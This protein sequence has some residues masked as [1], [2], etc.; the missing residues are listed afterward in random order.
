MLSTKRGKDETKAR[1]LWISNLFTCCKSRRC[2]A[3]VV[4]ISTRFLRHGDA[5]VAFQC[6]FSFIRH[7]LDCHNYSEPCLP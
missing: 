4:S 5:L 1:M 2:S 3:T 6:T 7:A